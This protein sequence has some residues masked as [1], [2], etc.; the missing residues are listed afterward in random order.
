MSQDQSPQESGDEAASAAAQPAP[1]N[2]SPAVPA[3][4]QSKTLERRKTGKRGGDSGRDWERD[5]LEK[6]ALA[7]TKEQ[8]RTRRWNLVLRFAFLIYIIA[9]PFL[10]FPPPWFGGESEGKHT[11]LVD[12]S[13]MIAAGREASAD[14]I[15]GGLRAAFEDENTAGV[16]VRINSPGGSP[17]Q[18]GYVNDEMRRLREKYPQIPTPKAVAA[19]LRPRLARPP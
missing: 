8:R 1:D 18:A 4:D 17:V 19:L 14:R 15:V 10:Y 12:I 5:V 13:G 7:A 2:T 6:L 11:A 3:A 9:V 16:V